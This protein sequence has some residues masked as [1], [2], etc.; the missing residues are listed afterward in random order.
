MRKISLLLLIGL[1]TIPTL[2]SYAGDD[3]KKWG[4]RAGFQAANFIDNGSTYGNAYNSF[5]AGFFGERKIIPLLRIGSGLDYM[6]TG[7]VDKDLSDTKYVRHTI[8]I[9]VYAKLKLGP[10]FVLG[11]IAANFKIVDKFTFL[12]EDIDLTDETKTKVF[13]APVFVGLGVKI[14][15][16]SIEARYHVGTINQSNIPDSNFS[17]QYFQ[18]GAGISF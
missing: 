17:P 13:N 2:F 1:L 12:N 9:P 10:V 18:I 11:G 8:S 5:Y 15:M 16:V 4:V 7:T 14:V 3:D 6:Q